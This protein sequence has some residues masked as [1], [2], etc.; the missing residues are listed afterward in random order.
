MITDGYWNKELKSL[1]NKLT[2]WQRISRHGS[3]AWVHHQINKYVLWSAILI[4]KITEDEFRAQKEIQDRKIRLD[5][6]F[7]VMNYT[8]KVSTFPFTGEKDFIPNRACE[9]MYDRKATDKTVA[10]HLICDQIIHS[11]VW[12]TVTKSGTTEVVGFVVSSDREKEKTMYY[13][14]LEEWIKAIRYCEEHANL[15]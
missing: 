7:L 8:V 10:L 14:S 3:T 4:R 11:W 1:A 5:P 6:P 9:G 13:V 2:C 12:D 15:T